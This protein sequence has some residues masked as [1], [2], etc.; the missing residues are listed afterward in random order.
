M[1]ALVR[2]IS[3]WILRTLFAVE[4]HGVE[5][6]P[7]HGAV[8]IAGNH[9]SYLDPVLVGLPVKRPLRFM[10]WDALFGVPVLGA[11]IRSLGAFPVDITRGKGEAAYLEARRILTQGEALGIFPEGQRSERGP[12]GDLRSGTAR[13]AIET[14]APIIPV[15]IGG[16][17]RAWPKWKL[18]PKPAKIIV[19]FHRSI[20]LD[21][22]ER[23]ARRDDREFQKQVTQDIADRINRSLAPALR[24]S[25]GLERRYRQPPSHIRSYEWAPLAVAIIATVISLVRGSVD[26]IAIWVPSLA[27]G[28]YLAA[29]L[30]L[31]PPSRLAKWVR[32]SMPI[33]LIF[34]WHFPLT[35]ALAID[36]G[37]MLVWLVGI[38]LGVFFVFFYE[39]YFNL[40]KFVRGI[41]VVY[42]FSLVLQ[43]LLPHALGLFA[44]ML[45]FIIIFTLTFRVTFRWVIATTLGLMLLLATLGTLEPRAPLTAYLILGALTILYL[46]SFASLAYDV[47]R[48]L[49]RSSQD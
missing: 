24:G 33:W 34:S 49:V 40:Q 36:P 30:A 48:Q 20:I 5:N 29:D 4:Y 11:L 46:Q 31:I 28:A 35:R 14:G 9:P 45:S 43:L 6:V 32:N 22:E 25:E 47:R 19:R 3:W 21:P 1:I 15:T 39:D 16:G 42:Y 27:Y 23:Q 37:V 44:A 12:M 26:W 38:L 8:I 18:L 10:A 13:L 41:V 7:L 2:L 17:Y